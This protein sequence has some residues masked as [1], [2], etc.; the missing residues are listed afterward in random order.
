M[1]DI[2]IELE[3]TNLMQELQRNAIVLETVVT[4]FSRL[5]ENINKDIEQVSK[6]YREK[7]GEIQNKI[8]ELT[9]IRGKSLKT[10]SGNITYVK[11][12][13]RRNWNLDALDII[14]EEDKYVKDKIWNLRE[15]KEGEPQ[16]RIK[17]DTKGISVTDI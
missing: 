3:L 15:E 7:S 10:G 12:A 5:I 16:V 4:P 11:G 13:V 14:C 2:E 1:E 9:F 8:K 17:V 6:P